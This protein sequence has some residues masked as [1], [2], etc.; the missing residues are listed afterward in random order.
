MELKLR[1]LRTLLETQ[2]DFNTKFK[3]AVN[4]LTAEEL[5]QKPI[6]KDLSGRLYWGH[7]D[8][9]ANLKV[10]REDPNE[11]GGDWTVVV[12]D[13]PTLVKLL[14]E[15]TGDDS[16]DLSPIVE[17]AAPVVDTGQNSSVS[18]EDDEQNG[19]LSEGTSEGDET[20][21]TETHNQ[22]AGKRS[23]EAPE[24]KEDKKLKATDESSE[25]I[26][27]PVLRVEG[28]GNGAECNAAN[29]TNLEFSEVVEEPVLY[30]RGTGSGAECDAANPERE[31]GPDS[32]VSTSSQQTANNVVST[33]SVDADAAPT[34]DS[35][36]GSAADADSTTAGSFSI[37]AENIIDSTSTVNTF[38][39]VREAVES[40]SREVSEVVTTSTVSNPNEEVSTSRETVGDV[41][42]SVSSQGFELGEPSSSDER[43]HR[44]A[45]GEPSSSESLGEIRIA[46][47]ASS[48]RGP[49]PEEEN[50]VGSS[51]AIADDSEEPPLSRDQVGSSESL[52]TPTEEDEGSSGQVGRQPPRLWSIQDICGAPEQEASSSESATA[53]SKLSFAINDVLDK[54]SSDCCSTASSNTELRSLE[55]PVEKNPEV[56]SPSEAQSSQCESE[57]IETAENTVPQDVKE[58]ADNGDVSLNREDTLISQNTSEIIPSLKTGEIVQLVESEF[59]NAQNY[60]GST[61]T[62][63]AIIITPTT[64]EPALSPSNESSSPIS[65]VILSEK[66]DLPAEATSVSN[67]ELVEPSKDTSAEIFNSDDVKREKSPSPAVINE[68][69]SD[70]PE[71]ATPVPCSEPLPAVAIPQDELTEEREEIATVEPLQFPSSE[72]PPSPSDT[73]D[74]SDNIPVESSEVAPTDSKQLDDG[75]DSE[76]L[77]PPDTAVLGSESDNL[78]LSDEPPV[79]QSLDSTLTSVAEMGESPCLR[80][81]SNL[82]SNDNLSNADITTTEVVSEKNTF[83]QDEVTVAVAPS[84][85][86]DTLSIRD[87]TNCEETP[88]SEQSSPLTALD[89]AEGSPTVNL[90]KVEDAGTPSVHEEVKESP[91]SN[92]GDRLES[93]RK[94]LQDEPD[95]L[96]A[97]TVQTN[98]VAAEDEKSCVEPNEAEINDSDKTASERND[99]DLKQTQSLLN[100]A[101]TKASHD[102]VVLN[103][104]DNTSSDISK[105]ETMV[106][107]FKKD[108]PTECLE[109]K[110]ILH[111]LETISKSEVGY[112]IPEKRVKSRKTPKKKDIADSEKSDGPLGGEPTS[113]DDETVVTAVNSAEVIEGVEKK[114]LKIEITSELLEP[115]DD[116][117]ELT[118]DGI[119]D[120]RQSIEKSKNEVTGTDQ[121]ELKEDKKTKKTGAETS[122]KQENLTI[123]LV[124]SQEAVVAVVSQTHNKSV[125]ANDLSTD[126]V[127]TNK[128]SELIK[129]TPDLEENREES[130]E[131][132]VEEKIK[133][134]K[135]RR[136]SSAAVVPTKKTLRSRRRTADSEPKSEKEPPEDQLKSKDDPLGLAGDQK[137]G[138][139][140]DE[141]DP[142]AT[143]ASPGK[144]ETQEGGGDLDPLALGED[145]SAPGT[146]MLPIVLLHC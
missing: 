122:L 82:D 118:L 87:G 47:S 115:P 18:D 116:K 66:N 50:E 129:E 90:T 33:S 24:E 29:P 138:G 76:V 26:Q 4:L 2:F 48:C 10:F 108:N 25:S 105:L 135:R 22:P 134:R 44:T 141:A 77:P 112:V 97:V 92:T 128:D 28:V 61:L 51:D 36:G 79:P 23:L 75:N 131:K 100:Y 64:P 103:T 93:D 34:P 5:R 143:P 1:L 57:V 37:A 110:P 39:E 3:A 96:P 119:K 114:S 6:G 95:V 84:P 63:P 70:T 16:L 14:Q 121:I 31:G 30:V 98:S 71:G 120:S 38:G 106:N 54:N 21:E 56:N 88:K 101:E 15:L 130:K 74:V 139:N 80:S 19:A 40:T 45:P 85:P 124:E 99:F 78:P 81:E 140:A 9:G 67:S 43:T 65:E 46:A 49:Q 102:S 72:D 20:E 73:K 113:E 137:E 91:N 32:E 107:D 132:P 127:E 59:Q 89:V 27:E 133:G 136:R 142:L 35:V 117:M 58:P 69:L 145:P 53:P 11:E 109:K 12:E 125:S 68:T 94:E 62:V 17:P 104:G 52:P 111:P 8:A 41:A 144:G 13:R 146:G 123:P 83:P 42:D 55:T 126:D 7:L 60:T 86:M